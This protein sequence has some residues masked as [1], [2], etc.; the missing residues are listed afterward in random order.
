MDYREFCN[1]YIPL[2][3]QM[4]RVAYHLLE[5]QPDAE[6]AVQD[7]YIKLWSNRDALD[8]VANPQGY[9]IT[10]IRNIC[11]DRI[12]KAS[13]TGQAPLEENAASVDPPDR[14][15]FAKEQIAR[16]R[17]AM[18]KL[19]EQQRQIFEMKVFEDLSYE[20][21]AEATGKSSVNLRVLMTLARNRIKRQL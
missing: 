10:L 8:A 1:I 15:A 14:Q 9:C 17:Q 3:E 6:D 12:R 11:I 13:R 4:Y 2:S 16:V 18:A 5:S 7:L 20:E 21:M 19:P